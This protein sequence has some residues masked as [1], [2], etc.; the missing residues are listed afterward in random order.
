MLVFIVYFRDIKRF[1]NI[2]RF[3]KILCIL[4]IIC[5]YISRILQCLT[6]FF[7]AVPSRLQLLRK[8]V[9]KIINTFHHFCLYLILE[10]V[11]GFSTC[12]HNNYV[13]DKVIYI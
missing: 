8:H 5:L 13:Q 2:F 3:C 4:F 11:Y 7:K 6:L 1:S 9:Q 10:I 12:F